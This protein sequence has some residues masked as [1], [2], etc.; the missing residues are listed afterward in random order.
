LTP[1]KYLQDKLPLKNKLIGFTFFC[2]LNQSSWLGKTIGQ[3]LAAKNFELA[4]YIPS[5]QRSNV[6]NRDNKFSMFS[7]GNSTGIFL[8]WMRLPRLQQII[9]NSLSFE[10]FTI[11]SKEHKHQ[12]SKQTKM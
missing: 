10:G 3:Y 6:P 12:Q 11:I 1:V 7:F 5:S 8:I 9:N 4:H 2:S